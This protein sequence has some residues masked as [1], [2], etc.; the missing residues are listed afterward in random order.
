MIGTIAMT[1]SLPSYQCTGPKFGG[2]RSTESSEATN[3][4]AVLA[5]GR[6]VM[7]RK[8]VGSGR[9]PDV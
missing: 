3:L 8:A 9:S 1:T 7:G 5:K 6:S 4:P 2:F